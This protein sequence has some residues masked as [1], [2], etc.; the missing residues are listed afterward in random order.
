MDRIDRI[1]TKDECR[2]MNDEVRQFVFN[3]S[4]RIPTSSFLNLVSPVHPV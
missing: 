3:S 1:K 4:F 2:M